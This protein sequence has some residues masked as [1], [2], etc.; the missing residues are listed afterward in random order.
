MS[1][2]LKYKLVQNIKYGKL[3]SFYEDRL[4]EVRNGTI[5]PQLF[6]DLWFQSQ[7]FYTQQIEEENSERKRQEWQRERDATTFTDEQTQAYHNQI[8][9]DTADYSWASSK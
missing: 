5:V 3:K 8:L 6:W 1:G 7:N 9:K 4:E 2:D